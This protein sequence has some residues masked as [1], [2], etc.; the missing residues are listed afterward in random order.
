[1]LVTEF[2]LLGSDG[3]VWIVWLNFLDPPGYNIAPKS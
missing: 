3:T 2:A 1:V